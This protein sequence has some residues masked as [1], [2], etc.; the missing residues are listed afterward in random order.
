MN[1]KSIQI[2]VEIA[3]FQEEMKTQKSNQSIKAE[4]EGPADDWSRVG[5]GMENCVKFPSSTSC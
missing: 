2:N 4:R 5:E 3:R 1:P